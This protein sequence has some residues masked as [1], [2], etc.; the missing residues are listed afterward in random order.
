MDKEQQK[1]IANRVRLVAK[2]LLW[3]SK[4]LQAIYE[5]IRTDED[6]PLEDPNQTKM[7]F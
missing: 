5:A 6:P 3:A 2:E 1:Q 4:N 7:N